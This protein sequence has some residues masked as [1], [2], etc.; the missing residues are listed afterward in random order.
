MAKVN[1]LTSVMKRTRHPERRMAVPVTAKGRKNPPASYMKAP[2]TGP[3]V[4]PKLNEASHQA[5]KEEFYSQLF[6]KL[7]LTVAFLS[8]NLAIKME[9]FEVQVA[10]A[11][12][13]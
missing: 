6:G 2:I 10:A 11:P 8:G 1:V 7:T 12:T 3:I 4:R 9:R 13:P 5:C